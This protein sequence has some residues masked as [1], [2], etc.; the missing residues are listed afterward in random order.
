MR[1]REEIKII[2]FLRDKK[3]A[4]IYEIH[5]NTGVKM[6]IILRMIKS[7]RLYQ[8]GVIIDY[9]CE[10]CGT[11]ISEGRVCKP[12]SDNILNQM[13]PEKTQESENETK[14]RGTMYSF[15]LKHN[16]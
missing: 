15:G 6:K 11:L 13:Q 16:R 10:S 9:P 3:R 4:S 5:D 7:G 1:L 12:C 8:S 2:E 14:I